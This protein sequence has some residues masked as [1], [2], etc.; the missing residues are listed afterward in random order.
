VAS[1]SRVKGRVP[2]DLRF[3]HTAKRRWNGQGESRDAIRGTGWPG[4]WTTQQDAAANVIRETGH[5]LV[6]TA[7]A[8]ISGVAVVLGIA[9]WLL[10]TGPVSL[11]FLTPYLRSALASGDGEYRIDFDDTVLAWAGWEKT[12]DI[13]VL[14]LRLADKRGF[15]VARIPE[16]SFGLDG[17][18]LVEGKIAFTS[19]DLL[20]PVLFLV[21]TESGRVGLDSGDR[22]DP[23]GGPAVAALIAALIEPTN[24]NSALG[25][26]SRVSIIDAE[27]TVIDER[28]KRTWHAP[29]VDVVLTRDSAG[30]RGD[31]SLRVD[32]GD[33]S[34]RLDA[35]AI[36]DA[37]A[38]TVAIEMSVPEIDPS[39]IA[40]LHG[41]FASLD[42]VRA[43]VTGTV[44]LTFGTDGITGPISFDLVSGPGEVR[45][46]A[47]F[48]NPIPF[49]QVSIRGAL[50]DSLS[51][52]RLDEAFLQADG[53]SVTLSGLIALDER[54]GAR[55]QGEFKGLPVNDLER[56]WPFGLEHLARDWVTT[57]VR[58]GTITHGTFRVDTDALRGHAGAT[59]TTPAIDVDFS[60]EGVGARYLS[61]MPGVTGGRGSGR[62]TNARLDLTVSEARMGALVLSEGAV[63][64]TELDSLHSTA[65]ISFVAAGEVGEAL[66]ILDREPYRFA[67]AIGLVPGKMSGLAAARVRFEIP[68]EK[69][70]AF[71]QVRYAAAA[72]LRELAV[73]AIVGGHDLTKGNL[74]LEI[75]ANGVRA[76]GSADISGVPCDIEWLRAFNAES[77]AAGRLVLRGRFDDAQR[78][79]FGLPGAPWIRG[80][81]PVEAE[82]LTQGWTILE[83]YARADLG[84]VAFEI[85]EL[86]WRKPDGAPARA[87]IS[88]RPVEDGGIRVEAFNIEGPELAIAGQAEVGPG[89]DLRMLDISDLR[90]GKSQVSVSVRPRAPTGFIVAL[91]GER[92]D[93]RPY[94]A[95]L[96]GGDESAR[97][98]SLVLSARVGEVLLDDRHAIRGVEGRADYSGER[99]EEIA[100]SGVL[101][102]VVPVDIMLVPAGEGR[103]LTLESADAG[104][105]LKAIGVFS[106]AEGGRLM[107]DTTIG[108]P[109]DASSVSGSMRIDTFRVLNAPVLARIL[110]VGSLTGMVDTLNGEGIS[111]SQFEAPFELHEKHLE[112]RDARAVG[113]AL[114][115][116]LTG[117]IDRTTE[118]IDIR[119]TLVP[120]YTLNSLLGNIPVLGNFLVGR[121]GEGVFAMTYSVSGTTD[122]PVVTV[123]PLSALAP[124]F[125]RFLVSGEPA[126]SGPEPEP[127]AEPG[128]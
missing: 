54:P 49:Q 6:R 40:P 110:T 113:S 45:V 69:D 52:V 99:W 96:M 26:L 77:G 8:A 34:P 79:R 1:E 47:V 59:A 61:A 121:K 51:A 31:V 127:V 19:L 105:F 89:G 32:L 80:V 75:D 101:N 58:G 74:A 64:L 41:S 20:R 68:L 25:R 42:S 116:T 38:H 118:N 22:A 123:N 33:T 125:L 53:T 72:N 128:R 10:S 2:S 43:P 46:P 95:R 37:S 39:T 119:G 60:F 93:M 35:R 12:L 120:S 107:V 50:V 126:D 17:I 57:R 122:S 108:E 5:L 16:A 90:Q 106:N 7:A 91:E 66:S 81:L 21:R 103:R 27:V 73:P 4:F 85:P 30:I 115:I 112:I 98:P 104:A 94:L 23:S 65:H 63:A 18:R 3:G 11:G 48:E 13:R 92:F 9:G 114:G 111:F 76:R 56:Y 88:A 71:S 29:D 67:A 55:V 117:T 100:A 28:L 36:Y 24:P 102:D 86:A 44:A 87:V 15:P 62:L 84:P 97:I 14:G 70:L 78:R 82:I 109:G 83:T 124:G